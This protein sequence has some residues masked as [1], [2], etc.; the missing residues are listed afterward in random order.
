MGKSIFRIGALVIPV[1]MAHQSDKPFFT[2][3]FLWLYDIY[4]GCVGTPLDEDKAFLP[5]K[6]N[7][8]NFNQMLDD[9]SKDGKRNEI[10][11]R[12]KKVYY[13]E[14]GSI[15]NVGKSFLDKISQTTLTYEMLKKTLKFIPYNGDKGLAVHIYH[16]L[17]IPILK[18]KYHKNQNHYYLF[19]LKVLRIK[20][21]AANR[22]IYL[23]G[24]IKIADVS[25][26]GRYNYFEATNDKVKEECKDKYA[27][28]ELIM[29]K[30]NSC[31]PWWRKILN[32]Q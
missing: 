30:P 26:W 20:F 9:V 4:K 2:N 29:K 10:G 22:E 25:Y 16:F 32:R 18:I 31:Y 12:C 21:T 23:L 15:E 6:K 27:I 24:R 17:R 11:K 13:D 19:G 28:S 14:F 3:K 1:I 8:K 5:I 7:L